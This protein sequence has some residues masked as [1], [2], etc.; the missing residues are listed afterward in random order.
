[1]NKAP[2]VAIKFKCSSK[3]IIPKITDQKIC[4]YT[5]QYKDPKNFDAL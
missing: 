4:K 3:N 5:K 2:I 1:M